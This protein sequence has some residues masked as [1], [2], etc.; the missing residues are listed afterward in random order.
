MSYEDQIEA[1][2]EREFAVYQRQIDRLG[3]VIDRRENRIRELEAE[4]RDLR[5]EIATL[6]A[7]NELSTALRDPR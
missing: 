1:A 2:A 6:L 7:E 3:E 4:N 5:A